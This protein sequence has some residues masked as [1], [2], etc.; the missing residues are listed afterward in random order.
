MDI[1]I[2]IT[3]YGEK[4]ILKNMLEIY[5]HDMSEF[6]DE[7]DKLELNGAGLYGYRYLDY[8]WNEKGRY[9]YLLTVDGRLAGF[10]LIRT[11][12]AADLTFE[13]AEFFIARKYRRRGIG[14]ILIKRMFELH[15][16]RWAINTPIKNLKAQCFWRKAV[17]DASAGDYKEYLSEGGRRL[18]WT[19]GCC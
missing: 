7:E 18:E 9:P 1:D 15:K 3:P 17:A 8:Y 16:G 14:S 19:F 4:H 10:C 5:L 12:D 11:L 13:V 2:F 6:D